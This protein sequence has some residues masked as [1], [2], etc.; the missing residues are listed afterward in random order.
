MVRILILTSLAAAI[1][2]NVAAAERLFDFNSYPLNQTPPGFKSVISGKGQPGDWKIILDEVPATIAPVT[3]QAPAVAKRPV[4]AQLSEDLTDEHCPLLIFEEDSY[5]DFTISF[6]FK[7]VKGVAEEMAGVAFRI[8]DENNYYYVRASSIGNSFKFF[9][10]VK[11]ER[12]PAIG[13]D[14]IEIPQGTWHSMKINCLGNQINC[15]LDEKQIIPTLTDNTFT[16]GKVVFWTKSDSVS[17]F[18]DVKL[19]FTPR[20]SLAHALVRQSLQ[21]YPRL[22]GLRIYGAKKPGEMR[23]VA[24]NDEKDIGLP[25]GEPEQGSISKNSTYF[26]KD[27]RIVT[28]TFPLHDRNG[29]A[30]A[31]VRIQMETFAGQTEQ[32]ALARGLPIVKEMEKQLQ[33]N[34]DPL[35]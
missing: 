25:G 29:D 33:G 7:T 20:E 22:K 5:G 14:N 31:A 16:A 8:Q 15:Y 17:Y 2:W 24:S 26:G 6:R 13:A 23:V 28:V 35:F 1:S 19:T 21:K 34:T 3:P 4:L 11:G 27:N 12:G 32:N 9:K 10:V 30:I 18:S